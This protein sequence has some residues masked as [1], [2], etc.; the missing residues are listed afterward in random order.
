MHVHKQ[1]K[2]LLWVTSAKDYFPLKA[3]FLDVCNLLELHCRI[4]CSEVVNAYSC[5][6]LLNRNKHQ[7]VIFAIKI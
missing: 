6:F 1:E 2:G 5:R 3:E 7:Y 4:R